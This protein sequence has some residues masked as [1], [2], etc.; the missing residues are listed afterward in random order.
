MASG[1]AAY[2][3]PIHAE[4]HHLSSDRRLQLFSPTAVAAPVACVTEAKLVRRAG[5]VRLL[6]DQQ[7]GR[8]FV[9]RGLEAPSGRK[10]VRADALRTLVREEVVARETRFGSDEADTDDEIERLKTLGFGSLSQCVAK[11]AT[12]RVKATPRAKVWPKKDVDWR[13]DSSDSGGCDEDS[14]V[15]ESRLN[16]PDVYR[17]ERILDARDGPSGRQ[18]L[19]KWEGWSSRWNDWEP[20]EYILDQRMLRRFWRKRGRAECAGETLRVGSKRSGASATAHRAREAANA[21]EDS[22]EDGADS[23]S[24]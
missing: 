8:Q 12:P 22:E 20:E 9:L 10:A 7:L 23:S 14:G 13:H 18:Y 4:P 21:D 17:V 11:A 19:I 1:E 3:R 5:A 16:E 15:D 2:A 6:T 24:E